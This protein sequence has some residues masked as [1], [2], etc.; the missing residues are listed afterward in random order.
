MALNHARD[1]ECELEIACA[2]DGTILALRGHA[3]ADLGAYLRTN[4][5]TAARNMSQMMSGPYRIPNIRMEVTLVMT[6]KTPSGTYRGRAGSKPISVAS[7][8]STWRRPI[9]A[10]IASSFAGVI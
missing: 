7:G 2:R 1:A 3:F 9:S 4:G 6:N 5:A 10:S 8:C